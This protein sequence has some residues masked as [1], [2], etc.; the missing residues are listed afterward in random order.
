MSRLRK[1]RRRVRRRSAIPECYRASH[2]L[3][4]NP[5]C[6]CSPF[7]FA[8]RP[9]WRTGP[10]GIPPATGCPQL[11][12]EVPALESGKRLGGRTNPDGTCRQL[13]PRADPYLSP[14]ALAHQPKPFGSHLLAR[15]RAP[16]E[17]VAKQ[18]ASLAV[19]HQPHPEKS[20][21]RRPIQSVPHAPYCLPCTAPFLAHTFPTQSSKPNTL[22]PFLP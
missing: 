7:E 9:S 21:R 4:T 22:P 19:F 6:S 18:L 13:R 5:S 3:G 11:D 17:L 10:P 12:H 20:F 8:Y 16:E 15:I 14:R 2:S 1:A